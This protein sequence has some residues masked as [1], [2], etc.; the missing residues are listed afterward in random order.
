[1][2]A[3][4][5]ESLAARNRACS[6][7]LLGMAAPAVTVETH[8][9][10]GLPGFTLVGLPETAVREARDRVRAA[11]ATCGFTWPAGRIT[12]HLGPADLPKEGGRFDL[13]I[14][15][16]LLAAT[17]QLPAA[18][19]A[20]C[21]LYGELGLDGRVL[22]ARGLLPALI[23]AQ[24]AGRLAVVP[25]ANADEAALAGLAG[26]RR[27]PPRLVG[28]LLE[29]TAWLRGQRELP[30]C[31][32]AELAAA[33]V[34]AP[35]L[36]DVRGQ[37]VAK[38]ALAVTA[39]G[40]HNL[41]LI[42]PP[43]TG[44]TML[45]ARLPGLLPTLAM[46]E[47]L[48]VAAVRSA[49]GVANEPGSFLVRPWRSPHHSAST[50]ALVGGGSVPRPGEVSLAH[51]GVLFLDELPEFQRRVLE[52]LREPLESGRITLSRAARQADYPARFQLLAA[53]NPCPCGY[54]G[55][56]SGRCHCSAEQLRR[57]RLR[58]SG[59]LLD[60]IDLHV[61][62]PRVDLHAAALPQGEP[63]A[64]VAARVAAARERQIRRQGMLNAWLPAATLR[65]LATPDAAGR[66][67]LQAAARRHALSARAQDRILRVALT[68]ADLDR[69]SE[70]PGETPGEHPGEVAPAP[71]QLAQAMGLR[72]LDRAGAS[73]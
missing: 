70:T 1:M 2:S 40:G 21:E 44:K 43:G 48:E 23:A 41:L 29:L 51:H 3:T 37:V 46:H 31:P 68:L 67:L 7:A 22:P 15:A 28:H 69:A 9:P 60:R 6:R 58:V 63:S 72:C 33:P 35:D 27:E 39:A 66:R 64:V 19:L 20:G 26:N 49:A 55:D 71:A 54:H 45:A 30:G 56:P 52:T 36:A 24:G 5:S 13:P 38:Q 65:E 16:A 4:T 73:H 25:Q 12:V 59:P 50:A 10:G 61:E 8:L 34:T 42:G 53:M 17:R 18:A 47:A 14:A 32:A 62:V 11:L 57:Y